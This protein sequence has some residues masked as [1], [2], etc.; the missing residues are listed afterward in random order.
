MLKVISINIEGSNTLFKTLQ[1]NESGVTAAQP[2][3]VETD[4]KS[5]HLIGLVFNQFNQL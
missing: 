1:W 4:D 2:R 3:N 5:I